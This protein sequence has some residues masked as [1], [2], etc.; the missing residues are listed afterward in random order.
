MILQD[1]VLKEY[2]KNVYFISGTAC[3][4]KTTASRE[5][6]KRYGLAVFD[7]DEEFA[8][9]QKQSDARWQ[10]AMNTTFKDADAFF[11]R[12]TEDYVRWLRDNTRE[13][14]D[15]ILMDLICL[16]QTQKIV[17]DL[18]LTVEEAERF[19]VPQRIAFLIREPANIIEEY[20]NRPDHSD[21]NAYIHS[22]TH[23][24]QAKANCNTALVLLNQAKFEQ[25]KKSPYFWLEKTANSTVE[26]TVQ[27]IAAHFGLA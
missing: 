1:N 17:C 25:I 5:L 3:G 18:H 6:A 11:G 12:S 22:A 21:F 2:L 14:L 19:T 26:Q 23:P 24:E 13:Q 7:V 15:F 9:H 8:R 10:P 20:C 4:G 27:K 16:S